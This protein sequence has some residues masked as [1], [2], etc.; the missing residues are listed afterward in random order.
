MPK[1]PENQIIQNEISNNDSLMND[2]LD[3]LREPNIIAKNDDEII[4]QFLESESLPNDVTTEIITEFLNLESNLLNAFGNKLNGKWAINETRGGLP[5]NPPIGWIGFGLDVINKYDNKNNDWLAC[6][7]RDGEWC[8]AYHGCGRNVSSNE[9]RIIIKSILKNNLKPG[10][11]QS[12][13]NDKDMNNQLKKVGR[14]VYCSPDI[15]VLEEYAGFININGKRYKVGIMLR[16][17]RD[18]IRIPMSHRNYWVLDGN[19]DQ[20][21]PYRLLIK[22]A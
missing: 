10:R 7:G 4:Q 9:V 18:K 13:Q 12:F 1:L 2:L 5:Y 8:V 14:G 3:I 6:D 15:N 20:L 21:R 11:G 16:C 22:Q 19:F 17:R